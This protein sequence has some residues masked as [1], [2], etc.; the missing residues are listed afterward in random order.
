M[1]RNFM[2]FGANVPE[3]MF[4]TRDIFREMMFFTRDI[5]RVMILH[6][7]NRRRIVGLS[8]F[9]VRVFGLFLWFLSKNPK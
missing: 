7:S 5:F 8:T 1:I 4:F 2:I 6:T 9:N 3:M